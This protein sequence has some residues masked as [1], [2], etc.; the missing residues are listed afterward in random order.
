MN[1]NMQEQIWNSNYEELLYIKGIMYGTG[2]VLVDIWL[3][4]EGLDQYSIEKISQLKPLS[5]CYEFK[6]ESQIFLKILIQG[7]ARMIFFHPEK[8]V[9]SF[10]EGRFK[11]GVQ[12]DFGRFLD[13]WENS[14]HFQEHQSYT[15]WFPSK[16][17]KG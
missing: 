4:T 6:E 1:T 2:G 16:T 3:L 5:C 14:L 15:G 10:K 11:K 17:D 12:Y 8:G 9:L 13:Q 7:Y